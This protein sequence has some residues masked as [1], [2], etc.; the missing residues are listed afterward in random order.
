[1]KKYTSKLVSLFGF[2]IT[3]SFC[4]CVSQGVQ[5]HSFEVRV[6]NSL[7]DASME[8]HAIGVNPVEATRFAEMSVSDYWKSGNPVRMSNTPQKVKFNLPSQERMK[9]SSESPVWNEW[10]SRGATEIVFIADLPGDYE[11]KRGNSDRR[12]IILPLDSN[13]W[14]GDF[15]DDQAIVIDIGPNGII[16]MPIPIEKENK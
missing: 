1:M 7:K 11:D 10:L 8:I 2:A 13:C 12:R 9:L 16:S 4:G 6:D 15:S 14:E 3:V 5:P